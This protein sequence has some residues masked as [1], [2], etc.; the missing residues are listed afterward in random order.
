MDVAT[1]WRLDGLKRITHGFIFNISISK[2]GSVPFY[3]NKETIEQA[4]FFMFWLEGSF[5]EFIS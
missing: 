2:I 5:K 4:I 3:S 1:F